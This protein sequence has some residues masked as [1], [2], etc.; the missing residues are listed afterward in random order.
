MPHADEMGEDPF[1][2]EGNQEN[3]EQANETV[4]DSDDDRREEEVNHDVTG[5]GDARSQRHGEQPTEVI[6]RQKKGKGPE[7]CV[8]A[9]LP[10]CSCKRKCLDKIPEERRVEIHRQCWALPYDRRRVFIYNSV[11]QVPKKRQRIR[12]DSVGGGSR[13]ASRYYNVNDSAGE[14]MIVCKTFFLNTLVTRQIS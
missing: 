2:A 13:N 7:E 8:K 9:L 4:P 3:P 5:N 10:P 11:K 1:T 14:E 12:E 6:H